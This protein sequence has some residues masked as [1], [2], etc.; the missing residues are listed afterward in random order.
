MRLDKKVLLI[1][2]GLL[3]LAAITMTPSQATSGGD[4]VLSHAL[5]VDGVVYLESSHGG[6]F[7]F[8]YETPD[9]N[10]TLAFTQRHLWTGNGSENLPCEG[11][12]HWID[13]KNVLTISHCLPYTQPTTTTIPEVVTDLPELPNTGVPART[14]GYAGVAFMVLGIATL[15][16]LKRN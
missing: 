14:F 16:A 9:T 15:S 12:I 6:A 4:T 8:H 11:G 13:N 5:E 3:V 7:T 10:P 1:V 2:G